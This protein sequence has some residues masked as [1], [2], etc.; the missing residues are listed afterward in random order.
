MKRFKRRR[1]DIQTAERDGHLY[2]RHLDPPKTLIGW[3][4]P[5]LDVWKVAFEEAKEQLEEDPDLDPDTFPNA[6]ESLMDIYAPPVFPSNHNARYFE[7]GSKDVFAVNIFN[8]KSKNEVYRCTPI[9]KR[10]MRLR[11]SIIGDN[12]YIMNENDE[13]MLK[14]PVLPR[15]FFNEAYLL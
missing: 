15:L 4:S 2:L 7:F 8:R 13:E 6:P 5:S 11:P 1:E 3:K 10:F 9:P 12:E 14:M